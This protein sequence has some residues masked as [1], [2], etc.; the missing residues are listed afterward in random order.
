MTAC[1]SC[2]LF[3]VLGT[4]TIALAQQ[5][6]AKPAFEVASIKPFDPD[7]SR[8]MWTGMNADPGIVHYSNITLKACIRAAYRVRD[9][10]IKGPAWMDDARFEITAKLPSGA[11]Q[12]Q[13]PEMLQALLADRFKLVLS[14]EMKEQSVYALV[15]APGGPVLK[16]AE[17]KADSK[18][19]TSVGPD[20]R[21]RALIGYQALP[22]GML[23]NATSASLAVVAELV[24][25]FTEQPVVDMTGLD[26]QY[27]IKFTFAPET[28]TNLPPAGTTAPDGRVLFSEPGVTLSDAIRKYGLKIEKRK[29]PIEI[30]TVTRL[31]RAPTDN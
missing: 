27:E 18:A 2:G 16:H 12:D 28:T 31:E 24:S 5:P 20:G 30:L 11:H 26:G 15:I 8:Q 17:M 22:S 25:R 9:F 21:P 14:H 19:P 3:I 7:P 29:A 6:L 10:Q 4:T 23:I 13:I 1:V